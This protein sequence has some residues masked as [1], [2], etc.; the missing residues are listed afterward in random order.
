[1]EKNNQITRRTFIKGAAIAGAAF[2][3]V[4][5]F[6]LGKGYVAPSDTLYIAGIG[7]GGR[8]KEDLVQSVKHPNARIAFLCDVDDKMAADSVARFPEA[9]YFKDFRI[10]FDKEHKHIDA[11]TVS[12]PDHTHTVAAMA[13][14]QRGK[15]VMVQKPLTWSIAEAR[16]L[17]EAARK[18]KVV[19]QMGNQGASGDD[20]RRMKE[21]YDA[22]LIGDVKHVWAWTNRPVWPQSVPTPSGQHEIPATLDWDLWIGPA[23]K[24]E[25]NPAYH[26]FNWRGWW[27]F[28]TGALGDMACHILD[29]FFRILPVN[30]P[31]EVECSATT[32]YKD[33]FVEGNYY[34]SAPASSI[35]HYNFPRTDN[36]GNIT[37]TWMDGGLLPKRPEELLPNEAMGDR[38]G[39]L[40]MEGTKGKMMSGMWGRG[41]TLLPTKLMQEVTLPSPT[42]PRIPQGTDGHYAQWVEACL[43]GY[44]KGVTSSPFDYAGP[45]TESVLMGNLA[46]RSYNIKIEK[47]GYPGRKKLLWDAQ[48]MRITNFE[49]GNQF[50]SRGY[51]EGWEIK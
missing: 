28:G 4:P 44:K 39:G 37:L 41:V 5:R 49:E 13:A 33:F 12:T 6:V 36:K 7:V 32:A 38:D 14:M 16:M 24:I 9:K 35:I 22:G 1:M 50:V 29:P 47:G 30:N 43:Q 21:M 3:I 19:T 17:T 11:V 15:H 25:Y 34:E 26:P 51:R 23:E 31:N 46:L 8:G 42:L 20:V 45:F 18:Y 2:T 48:Q 10:M 27:R 40:I